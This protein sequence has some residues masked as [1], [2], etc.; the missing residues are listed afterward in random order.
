MEFNST[1]RS[2]TRLKMLKMKIGNIQLREGDSDGGCS[3]AYCTDNIGGDRS[4]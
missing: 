2:G 4:S 1:I 3:M